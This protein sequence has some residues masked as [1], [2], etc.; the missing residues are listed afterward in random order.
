MSRVQYDGLIEIS[1]GLVVLVFRSIC[2]AAIVEGR[3]IARIKHDRLVKILD[4]AI[5]IALG[6]KCRRSSVGWWH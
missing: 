4:C 6:L 5:V 1:N 2:N 3:R